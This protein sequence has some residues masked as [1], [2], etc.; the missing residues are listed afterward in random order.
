MADNS[1]QVS[2]IFKYQ[3]YF[4]D[5]LLEAAVLPQGTGQLIADS[6]DAPAQDS[7]IKGYGIGL[8]PTAELPIAISFKM[9]GKISAAQIMRP[10]QVVIPFGR[11]KADEFD[12]FKWGIPTG[13]LGG[14]RATLTIIKSPRAELAWMGIRS[15]IVMQRQTMKIQAKTFDITAGLAGILPNWP[16][17][18]PSPG[19]RRG[20]ATGTVAQS[21]APV[22]TVDP[23]HTMIRLKKSAILTQPSSV[24]LLFFETK[25]FDTNSTGAVV[26]T[27]VGYQ[28]ITFPNDGAVGVNGPV[29]MPVQFYTDGIICRLGADPMQGG[30]T[31]IGVLAV[32]KGDGDDLSAAKLQIVRYGR[33]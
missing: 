16:I 10:G 14:G 25:E 12:G 5:T 4:D 17:R 31:G 2:A 6:A 20:S 28:D 23:S 21:G 27:P 33:L 24:R 7:D 19:T 3:S 11:T 29:Q 30:Q 8:D 15:P 13:W 1:F 32:D 22:M 18:F 9:G 26:T